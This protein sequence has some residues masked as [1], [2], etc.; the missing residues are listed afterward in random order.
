MSTYDYVVSRRHDR[1]VDETLS[2]FNQLGRNHNTN[3]TAPSISLSK[4][5]PVKVY[6]MVYLI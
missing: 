5:N 2:Q 4:L 3:S 6:F 1:T